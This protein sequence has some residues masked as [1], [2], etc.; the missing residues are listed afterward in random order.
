MTWRAFLAVFSALFCLRGGKAADLPVVHDG[1]TRRAFLS[2]LGVSAG[3]LATAPFDLDLP[4]V[5]DEP[6]GRH[7]F[8]TVDWITKEAL[9]VLEQNL[10]TV[11]FINRH[12]D[13]ALA[14]EV[15]RYR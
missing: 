12:Y 10:K 4:L 11:R 5:L 3:A 14:F 13:D 15:R 9:K 7:G 1:M 6:I 8:L 2:A